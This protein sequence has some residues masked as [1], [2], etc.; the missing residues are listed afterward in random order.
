MPP[1][2]LGNGQNYKVTGKVLF[3]FNAILDELDSRQAAICVLAEAH[4]DP[5][6]YKRMEEAVYAPRINVIADAFR[7]AQE[8]NLFPARFDV[9]LMIDALYGAVWYKVLIRFE[10]VNKADLYQKASDSSLHA[11]LTLPR[12][13]KSCSVPYP[14]SGG[15]QC[16]PHRC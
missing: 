13:C 4:R 10:K 8:K 6:L 16:S 9:D 2:A 15:F 5:Q 14:K 7:R 12:P 11:N 1:L 3:Y